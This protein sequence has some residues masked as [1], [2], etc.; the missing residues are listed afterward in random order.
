MKT[1]ALILASL[2]LS[3][4]ATAANVG[5]REG[6]EIYVLEQNLEGGYLNDWY[7]RENALRPEEGNEGVRNIIVRGRGKTVEFK[8]SLVMDCKNPARSYWAFAENF[9][10]DS[11]SVVPLEAIMNI[12][13][14]FCH[15]R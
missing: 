9:G 3:Q 11:E 12:R 2:T 6:N 5:Q 8:G 1:L 15:R 7:A 14:L 4:A 10:V 13:I